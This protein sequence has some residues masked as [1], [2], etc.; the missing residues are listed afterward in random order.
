MSLVRVLLK[1]GR[2]KRCGANMMQQLRQIC[3][4][5][6]RDWRLPVVWAIRVVRQVLLTSEHVHG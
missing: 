4:V 5:R 2:K 3:A 6:M 1:S